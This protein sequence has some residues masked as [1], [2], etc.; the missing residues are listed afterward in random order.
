VTAGDRNRLTDAVARSLVRHRQWWTAA[1]LLVLALALSLASRLSLRSAIEDF[2]PRGRRLADSVAALASGDVAQRD[3]ILVVLEADAPL[4]TEEV[5]P[6]LDTLAARL[7]R[8][9]GVRRA[10]ARLATELRRFLEREGPAHFLLFLTPR[11]LEA[12]G[13][14]LTRE[15]M[16]RALLD[17]TPPRS[18]NEALRRAGLHQV[19]PL[20]LGPLAL[21]VLGRAA[22]GAPVLLAHG[23]FVVPTWRAAVVVVEPARRLA[24]VEDARAL[25]GGVEHAVREVGDDPAYGGVLAGKRLLVVGRP[26]AYVRGNEVARAD[27]RRIAL[28]SAAALF[29]LLL[30]S[31]RRPLAPLII[32][33]TVAF[34]IAITGAIAV[35]VLGSV[36]LLAWIFVSVLGGLG[37]DFGLYIVTQY[38]VLADPASSRADALAA[39]LRRPGRGILFGGLTNAS[40]FVAL[41]VVSY[42]VIVELG[43]LTAVGMIVIL[44]LSFTVLPLALS[45]TAPGRLP[46]W[47]RWVRVVHASGLRHR[48]AGVAAWAVLVA[49]SL[50]AARSL[51]YEPHPWKV[52]LDANP[53]T[54]ELERVRRLVGASFTP[55]LMVSPGATAEEAIEHDR[56]AVRE[57][58][59]LRGRAGVGV[60][61][62]L[63]HWLPAPAE[64]RA[65][66][67]YVRAHADLFSPDRV[68]RDLL[69][70]VARTDR[71][72]SALVTSYLPLVGRLLSSRPAELRL[73]D[74]RRAGLDELLQR[75]LVGGGGDYH[76]VSYVYLRQMP[77]TA[78]AVERFTT[79][80]ERF[81]G[82]GLARVSF[83]GDALHGG[84][85]HTRLLRRDIVLACAAVTLLVVVVLSVALRRP[86]LVLLCGVPVVCCVTAALGL[87]AVLGIELNV[88]TLAIAPLLAGLG[89]DNGVHVVERL[90][91][92]EPLPLVLEETAPAMTMTTLANV[93]GFAC[94]GLATFPGVR[95]VGLV[96]AFGLLVSLAAALHL[97]PLLYSMIGSGE[98]GRGKGEG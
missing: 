90:R 55:V 62:S 58:E 42:P 72:D 26:V 97:V 16:T 9:P 48:G 87:M 50:W 92:G 40:A 66:I 39:A 36:S 28:A 77:W 49:A 19:D 41:V 7:A 2:L 59:R 14:R 69:S 51:G 83:G 54:A 71:P 93:A 75:H 27:A 30:A 25:V 95:Q 96:G 89:V 6:V 70:V 37:V 3:R 23:Y 8:V 60:I 56:A 67:A 65:T 33:G 35:L 22:G 94:L 21:G 1:C 17:T 52:V 79:T 32:L 76:A 29:L 88:M 45:F 10:Q 80:I 34:G 86:R 64:Q 91:R 53:A 31:F 15:S 44:A 85:S 13:E 38:W 20:G 57:L 24:G 73:D 68:R 98:E 11:Q 63:S 61:Q 78:G 46:A 47:T 5:G 12:L 82:P 81:G 18:L 4:R 84:V 74:L 43:W